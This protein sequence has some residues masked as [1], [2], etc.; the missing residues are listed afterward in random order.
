ML[1]PEWAEPLWRA[2]VAQAVPLHPLRPAAQHGGED[3]RGAQWARTLQGLAMHCYAP[4][5][6]QAAAR[7]AAATAAACG[8]V[9]GGHVPCPQVGASMA[10]AAEA[11]AH[12][13]GLSGK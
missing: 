3:A 5:Q 9:G 4:W 1:A 7:P 2:G 6:A 11:A 10:D 12:K 13:L 8:G